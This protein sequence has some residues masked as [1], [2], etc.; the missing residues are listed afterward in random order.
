MPAIILM[1]VWKNFGFNMLIFLA[2]LQSV[3]RH[4]YE[5]ARLDGAGSW[6]T[7]RHVTV[8]ML[9]PTFEFVAVLTSPAAS[10]SSPNPT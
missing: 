2:A 6:Q 7:F 4:L 8:P 1:A 9:V 10:S 5:A 3:P